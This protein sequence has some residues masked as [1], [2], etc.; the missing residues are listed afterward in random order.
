M[1]EFRTGAIVRASLG[2][3]VPA[4]DDP[5]RPHVAAEPLYPI[6]GRVLPLRYAD[7]AALIETLIGLPEPVRSFNGEGPECRLIILRPEQCEEVAL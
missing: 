7:G 1:I 6:T 4:H 3:S 2:E 5:L